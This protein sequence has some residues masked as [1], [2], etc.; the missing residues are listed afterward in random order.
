[1]QKHLMSLAG[2]KR[3]RETAGKPVFW[4]RVAEISASHEYYQTDCA[5]RDWVVPA[6]CPEA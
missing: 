6:G 1:M 4:L 5:L 3:G 2:G